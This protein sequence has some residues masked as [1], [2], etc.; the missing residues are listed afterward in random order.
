MLR[1]PIR[2]NNYNKGHAVGAGAPCTI[3]HLY[4]LYN[5]DLSMMIMKPVR[6]TG[7]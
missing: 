6:T 2:P 3:A 5:I 1:Y 7:D 4:R